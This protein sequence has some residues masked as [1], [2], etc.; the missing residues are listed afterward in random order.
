MF[1]WSQARV[2][3]PGWYGFGSAIAGYQEVMGAS[4]ADELRALYQS[5]PYFANLVSN[6]EM[7]LA[8]A[9]L[10]IARRY[11]ELV[12]DQDMAQA[13]FVR[14]EAEWQKTLDALQLV[15][16]RAE[17]VG[18]NPA[19]AHSISSRRPRGSTSRNRQKGHPIDDQRDIRWPA[20]Y[21]LIRV[22]AKP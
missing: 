12:D 15:T 8:K 22:S 5:S 9:N 18:N 2:N 10:E 13:I 4:A 3:L 14:I 1:S 7:V 20:E 17:L 16:G 6:I 21:G 11:S 19:L